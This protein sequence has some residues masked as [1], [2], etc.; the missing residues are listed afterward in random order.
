M[1]KPTKKMT[2]IISRYYHEKIQ[3]GSD[4][5]NIIANAIR[6]R[7]PGCN[8]LV[9]GAGYDSA[10]WEKINYDGYTLVVEHHPEW[11][12][13]MAQ[14]AN[15]KPISYPEISVRDSLPINIENMEKYDVPRILKEKSWDVIIVDSPPGYT[16]TDPGRSFSIY[17]ASR[18]SG[19]H[20]HIFVDDY[21]RPV[22]KCYADTFVRSD[23]SCCLE[24]ARWSG[25][26]ML[27][28]WRVGKDKG[29]NPVFSVD[30]P[31][32]RRPI[33]WLVNEPDFRVVMFHDA[34]LPISDM[35]NLGLF[36][37][38]TFAVVSFSW[39]VNEKRI[40]D[41]KTFFGDL[42]EKIGASNVFKNQVILI[43]NSQEEY[44]MAKAALPECNI[45]Y[46]NNTC[47]LDIDL[48]KAETGIEKKYDAV[49]NAKPLAFKRHHLTSTVD[50]KVFITYDVNE[51]NE[52]LTA[53][54]DIN[55]FSPTLV[56]KNISSKRV[57]EVA[58]SAYVGLSLSEVEGACYASTEYLLCGL[59]V[60]STPSQGGRDAFYDE[61]NSLICAPDPNEVAR[62]VAEL[63]RRLLNGEITSEQIRENCIKR[64]DF[65][66]HSFIDALKICIRKAGINTPDKRIE[67]IVM[68][69]IKNNNKLIN[70]RNF[71]TSRVER[72]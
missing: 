33:R 58:S 55:E 48:F 5:V 17:W 65:F 66:R 20:T 47:F 52:G 37:E 31:A 22:E 40:G 7:A 72:G 39:V 25:R 54:V 3:I 70:S 14:F 4:Q 56:E 59:P 16:D 49:Y 46:V 29:F 64:I 50:S 28:L 53:S 26:K 51:A 19:A 10:L 45:A 42:A 62:S 2:G 60:V 23:D 30:Y 11:C 6:G 32:T 68:N 67:S 27:M 35:F 69:A 63:K 34:T 43:M 18:I 44:E 61:Y 9:F 1:T 12:R 41:L 8:L 71:W 36:D 57:M 21:E 13:N 38:T 15:V 24:I